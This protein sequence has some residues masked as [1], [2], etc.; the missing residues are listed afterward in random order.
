[1]FLKPRQLTLA[2]FVVGSSLHAAPDW[3]SVEP[4]LAAKCYECHNAEKTKGDVDLK[5]FAADPK[6]AVEFDL[7]QKVK[8]SIEN[9]D[10]PPKK[11]KALNP[12]EKEGITGWVTHSLD[13][14]AEEGVLGPRAFETPR[15]P[16]DL[17]ELPAVQTP[18]VE[19]TLDTAADHMGRPHS[20]AQRHGVGD[21]LEITRPR[22]SS[23]LRQLHR[24]HPKPGWR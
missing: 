10:M 8:D 5:Q 2:A 6:L 18:A 9:G 20:L 24:G 22:H 23:R 15:L 12:A 11:A 1:M 13:A 21:A 14:L 17:H 7:W 16:L 3:K 4:F 19:G